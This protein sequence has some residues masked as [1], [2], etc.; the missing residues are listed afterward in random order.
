MS[1]TI[2]SVT[3]SQQTRG[4]Q[5]VITI[6]QQQT[7]VTINDKV[8]TRKTQPQQWKQLLEN[9]QSIKLANLPAIK[10]SIERSAVDAAYSAQVTVKTDK[11]AYESNFFD[12]TTPPNELANVVKTIIASAKGIAPEESTRN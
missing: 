9:L 2:E 7:Q 3:L 12:H 11:Q 10:T 1:E 5:K 4:Y 6:T 8:Y